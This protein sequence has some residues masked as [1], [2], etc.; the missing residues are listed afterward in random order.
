MGFIFSG[1]IPVA[2]GFSLTSPTPLDAFSIVRTRD[3]LN[4]PTHPTA[5]GVFLAEYRFLGRT[6]FVVDEGIEYQLK[7]G[8]TDEHW[9]VKGGSDAPIISAWA[10]ETEYL[11]GQIVWHAGQ[12][13]RCNTTHTSEEAPSTFDDEREN[14]DAASADLYTNEVPALTGFGSIAAGETF[15]NI[16]FAEFMERQFYPEIPPTGLL[17]ATPAFG[18]R[19]RGVPLSNIELSLAFEKTKYPVET[20]EFF[21][22]NVSIGDATITNPAGETVTLDNIDEDGLSNVTFKAEVT[23]TEGLQSATAETYTFVNPIYIGALSASLTAATVDEAD[24]KAMTKRTVQKANQSLSYTVSGEKL[25]IWIPGSWG[26]LSR[27]LDP[28]GFDMKTA[29]E[30]ADL[31]LENAG[32]EQVPGTI[33]ILR[34]PTTQ[35]AFNVTYHFA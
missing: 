25:A 4:L 35:T 2:T 28:N 26:N 5:P 11:E 21:R 9:E 17:T 29:F 6:V 34:L 18:V 20:V 31:P 13:W 1:G 12:L 22:N 15:E 14:F 24:V 10:N 8:L 16:T 19:E 7:K 3:N 27:I 32:G 30:S 23:D 33:H